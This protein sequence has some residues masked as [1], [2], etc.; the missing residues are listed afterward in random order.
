M[1]LG[2]FLWRDGCLHIYDKRV[3]CTTSGENTWRRV[4]QLCWRAL[5]SH[6]HP[7]WSKQQPAVLVRTT[8]SDAVN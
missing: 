5:N 2:A 8:T 4:N 7:R 3:Y 6:D 1:Y